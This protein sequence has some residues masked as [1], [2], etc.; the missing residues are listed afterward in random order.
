MK[1]DPILIDERTRAKMLK[2]MMAAAVALQKAQQRVKDAVAMGRA[3][4]LE[5]H[6]A[7]SWEEIGRALGVTKQAAQQRYGHIAL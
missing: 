6:C 4:D 5:G 3:S 2:E 1:K 7:L